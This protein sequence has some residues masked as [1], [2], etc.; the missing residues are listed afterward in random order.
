MSPSLPGIEQPMDEI[1]SFYPTVPLNHFGSAVNL[2]FHTSLTLV[3][4]WGVTA[5]LPLRCRCGLLPD[6]LGPRGNPRRRS[7]PQRQQRGAHAHH[8]DAV[9]RGGGLS[10][11]YGAEKRRDGFSPSHRHR[12]MSG[13]RQQ[14]CCRSPKVWRGFFFFLFFFFF[15][16]LGYAWKFA[17]LSS[18]GLGKAFAAVQLHAL[19]PLL[20]SGLHIKCIIL[21]KLDASLLNVCCCK[22][23]PA[24]LL[25]S[26]C[27]IS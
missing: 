20:P 9:R 12:L 21:S 10:C 22:Y 18:L 24:I 25:K 11:R 23:K 16:I 13:L 27:Y 5:G 2:Y 4:V 19:K 8:R 15:K 26:F 7:R 14:I 3:L 17:A 1:L 6:V